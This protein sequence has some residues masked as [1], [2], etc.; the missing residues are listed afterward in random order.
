MTKPQSKVVFSRVLRQTTVH[1]LIPRVSRHFS[2][3]K[4]TTT[5]IHKNPH[6]IRLSMLTL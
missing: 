4:K 6:I 2:Y 5:P 3:K 1:F